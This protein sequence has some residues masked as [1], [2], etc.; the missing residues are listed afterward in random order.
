MKALHLLTAAALLTGGAVVL[1]VVTVGAQPRSVE[2]RIDYASSAVAVDEVYSRPAGGSYSV[3]GRGYGHGY[4]MSQYGAYGAALKGLTSEQ[5]LDFYYPG[6]SLEASMGNSNLKVRLTALGSGGTQVKYQNGLL[7]QMGGKSASLYA[8]NADGSVREDWRIV[9]SGSGLVLQWLEKGSWRSTSSWRGSSLSLVNR[10]AGKVRVVMPDG[11]QRD[12]RRTV[13]THAYGSG[14]MTVNVLSLNYYLQSVVPAEMPPSWPTAA[15]EAQALAART[16][17]IHDKLSQ[18]KGSLFDTC[19]SSSCQVFRGLAGY[20]ASGTLTPYENSAT[21]AVVSRTVK[22]GLTYG[23]EPALTQFGSS[24]GGYTR[25]SSLPYQTSAYDRY[26]A[27]APG[28]TSRWSSTLSVAKVEAAYPSTGTLRAVRIRSR[29][30]ISTYGGRTTSITIEGSKGSTTVSGDAFR[31]ATGLRSTWWTVTSAP[32]TSAPAFPKD[33]DGNSRGDLLAIDTSRQLRLL[34]GNG[35]GSF[36]AA[37]VAPEWEKVDLIANVGAWTSDNRHDVVERD[38][39]TLYYH[40]GDGAGGFL[41]RLKISSGWDDINWIGGSGD[42]DGDGHTD[43]LVRTSRLGQLKIYRGD[44]AGRVLGTTLIGS[45][46]NAY[47][48]VVSPGDVT[49]DGAPDVIAVRA[50]DGVMLLFPNSGTGSLGSP[51]RVSGS[52]SGYTDLLGPGDVSGD[53]RGDLVGRRGSDGA[54]VLFVGD[55]MG[56]FV[57]TSVVSGT[58]TWSDWARWMS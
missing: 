52:W 27:V 2:P 30:G 58:S 24:N 12:Y 16:Y 55:D 43:F 44:G 56:S 25:A 49:G 41:P 31:S 9:R 36:T 46:W 19:D 15:L 47:S 14:A 13:R 51:G 57:E 34:S 28:S 37:V 5:I 1:P 23:G 18:P 3:S 54:L 11:T 6:T 48:T 40:A 39:G 35:T 4:G 50:S 38:K 33:L 21:T 22:L 45:S 20:S 26:D 32:A 17:A 7:V 53:G 42:M 8:R 29:D 10:V